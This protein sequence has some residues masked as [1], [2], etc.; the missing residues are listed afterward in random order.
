MSGPNFYMNHTGSGNNIVNLGRQKFDMTEKVMDEII[1]NLGST[2][3]L[4]LAAIGSQR[5]Q[6]AVDILAQFL[7]ARGFII[8]SISHIGMRVPPMSDPLSFEDGCIY[9]DADK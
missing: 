1:Q 4:D 8:H 5:S 6:I 2:R 3:V 7:K 9:V